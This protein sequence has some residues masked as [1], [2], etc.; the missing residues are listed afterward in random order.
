LAI[1]AKMRKNE[2]IAQKNYKFKDTF[3]GKRNILESVKKQKR[4]ILDK[5]PFRFERVPKPKRYKS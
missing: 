2:V 1:S 3:L 5:S 4:V